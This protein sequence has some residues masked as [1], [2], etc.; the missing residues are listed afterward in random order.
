MLKSVSKS[1][2]TA[3]ELIEIEVG[4]PEV[5]REWLS[6]YTESSERVGKWK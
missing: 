3:F 6:S 1:A 4:I 2:G 5:V